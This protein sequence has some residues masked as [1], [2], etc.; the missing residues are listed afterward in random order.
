MHVCMY[1]SLSL[2]IYIYMYTYN[3]YIYMY[4]EVKIC[5]RS[6]ENHDMILKYIIVW[7]IK[8]CIVV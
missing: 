2:Y 5:E 4:T 3:I 8:Q 7:C 1:L 6:G